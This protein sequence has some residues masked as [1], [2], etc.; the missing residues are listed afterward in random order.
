[1]E[2]R[3]LEEIL[4]ATGITKD[5]EDEPSR[6]GSNTCIGPPAQP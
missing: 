5:K 1:M 2:L 3:L 4:K 6:V